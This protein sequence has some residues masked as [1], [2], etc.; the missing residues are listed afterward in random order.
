MD[1][2]GDIIQSNTD[3]I[4]SH[5]VL[6]QKNIVEHVGDCTP[7]KVLWAHIKNTLIN[8]IDHFV[9]YATLLVVI[10]SAFLL[11]STVIAFYCLHGHLYNNII[12]LRLHCR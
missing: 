11:S 8:E 6:K 7:K 2:L 1:N 9:L 12:L 3:R 5:L 4:C 10:Q